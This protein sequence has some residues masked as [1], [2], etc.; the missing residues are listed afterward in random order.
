[1]TDSA[2]RRASKLPLLLA[3][4]AAADFQ[5]SRDHRRYAI[6]NTD[7]VFCRAVKGGAVVNVRA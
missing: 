2:P 5:Y 4:T 1:M 7:K 3:L 6:K